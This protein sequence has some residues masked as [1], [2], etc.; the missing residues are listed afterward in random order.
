MVR[1]NTEVRHR[2]GKI[3]GILLDEKSAEM[4]Y[5]YFHFLAVRTGA[6]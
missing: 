3:S 2:E 1:K 4:W 6:L 5:R